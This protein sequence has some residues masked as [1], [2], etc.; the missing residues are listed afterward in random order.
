MLA[1]ASVY[2]AINEAPD[3]PLS[4]GDGHWPELILK[5]W[6]VPIYVGDLNDMT[7]RCFVVSTS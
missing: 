1:L 4:S 3:W 2:G 6:S 5:W 7:P